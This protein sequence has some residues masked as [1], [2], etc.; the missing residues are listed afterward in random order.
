MIK[1]DQTGKPES[2]RRPT[3]AMLGVLNAVATGGWELGWSVGL[4]ARL[5]KPGLGRGG[6]VRHLN[7]NTFHGL[8]QRGLI[9]VAARGFPTTRY[10]ITE[11]GKRAIAA[12]S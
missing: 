12:A 7:A 11:L 1:V 8:H 5:Q 9:A 6:E 2:R 4:G 3:K 10:R